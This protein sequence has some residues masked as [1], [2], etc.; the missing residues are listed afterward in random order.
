MKITNRLSKMIKIL[1]SHSDLEVSHL[2]QE[3]S[4]LVIQP[5]NNSEMPSEVECQE[6]TVEEVADLDIW[7]DN[8][9]TWP[10]SA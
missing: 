3:D 7:L 4:D 9:W 10:I 1:D 6:V 2:V 8:G 5:S